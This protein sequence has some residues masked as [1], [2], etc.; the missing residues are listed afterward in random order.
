MS[1][2]PDGALPSAAPESA[3]PSLLQN[4]FVANSAITTASLECE[5]RRALAL[6]GP[7]AVVERIRQRHVLERQALAAAL[8]ELERAGG[9]SAE[10]A[11]RARDTLY[12]GVTRHVDEPSPGTSATA[13]ANGG[14]RAK[15][16]PEAAELREEVT[17]LEERLQA[18]EAREITRTGG[19]VGGRRGPWFVY[20]IETTTLRGASVDGLYAGPTY[21]DC[22]RAAVRLTGGAVTRGRPYHGGTVASPARAYDAP[23]LLARKDVSGASHDHALRVDVVGGKVVIADEDDPSPEEEAARDLGSSC[24]APEA[25]DRRTLSARA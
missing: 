17:Q 10:R 3:E 25:L 23:A 20:A 24:E 9:P 6:D 11:S 5:A 19:A 1:D 22:A 16:T 21:A 2:R 8:K 12:F 13:P 4:R 15:R 14:G 7:A 18:I